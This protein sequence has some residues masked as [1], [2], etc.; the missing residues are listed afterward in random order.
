MERG[1]FKMW[2]YFKYVVTMRKHML[3][4]FVCSHLPLTPTLWIFTNSLRCL[5]SPSAT[6]HLVPSLCL[7][8]L[9]KAELLIP[10]RD[11]YFWVFFIFMLPIL[12]PALLLLFYVILMFSLSFC[13]WLITWIS[14]TVSFY[15]YYSALYCSFTALH[16]FDA[17]GDSITVHPIIRGNVKKIENSPRT[18]TCRRPF[19][20]KPQLLKPSRHFVFMELLRPK[21]SWWCMGCFIPLKSSSSA[22]TWSGFPDVSLM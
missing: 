1:L 12:T 2:P 22:T 11:G 4:F 13:F 20:C 15:Q 17:K 18:S 21:V 14:F 7:L 9:P 6:S 5:H 19:F 10:S 16:Y 3:V 8:S